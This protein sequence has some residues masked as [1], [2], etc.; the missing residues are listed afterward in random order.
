VSLSV[1]V[2]RGLGRGSFDQAKHVRAWLV[3]PLPQVAHVIRG[4][5]L[6]IGDVSLGNVLHSR[7][8]VDL[9]DIHKRGTN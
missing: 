1:D 8:A 7:T 4:L 2:G 6:Q 3:N 9:V 5:G